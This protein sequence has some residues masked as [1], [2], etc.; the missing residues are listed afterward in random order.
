[1]ELIEDEVDSYLPPQILHD[2]HS[3][4]SP[5]LHLKLGDSFPFVPSTDHLNQLQI[6]QCMGDL[7]FQ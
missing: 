2:P 1:V 5:L 7:L 3:P 6:I 4:L